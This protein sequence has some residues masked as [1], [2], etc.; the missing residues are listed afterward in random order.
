MLESIEA[1]VPEVLEPQAEIGGTRWPRPVQ[2]PGAVTALGHEAGVAQHGE[3]LADGR[4]RDVESPRDLPGGQ[5]ALAH[6]S[7]DGPAAGLGKRLE[8]E[9]DHGY[10][11]ATTNVSVN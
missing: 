11:L 8:G 9:I 7:Q 4:P 5:L 6:E 10:T 1:A 2:A 3:M